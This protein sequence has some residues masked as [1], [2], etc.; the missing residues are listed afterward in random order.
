MTAELGERPLLL[1]SLTF[2][3]DGDEVVVGRRDI[4]SYGVFP[5][6]GAALLRELVAGR[7]LE[8][9][10]EWYFETFGER[11]D[12][13]EFVAVLHELSFIRAPTDP[14]AAQDDASTVSP[15]THVPGQALGKAAFSNAAWLCYAL[16]VLAAVWACVLDSGLTPMPSHVFFSPYLAVVELVVVFGQTPLIALHEA[17]HVLAGRRLGLT[18]RVRLS[19]RFLTPVVETALDGLVTVP[20]RQ[21]ALPMLAGMLADVLAVSGLTLVAAAT[22]RQDGTVSLLGGLCLALAFTTLP[23]IAWQFFLH[24]RTDLYHLVV[25]L[26]GCDDLH[27]AAKQVPLNQLNAA[28]GK[29]EK[30]REDNVGSRRDRAAARWYAPLL[31]S[32]YVASVAMA[33]GIVLPLAWRFITMTIDRLTGSAASTATFWDAAVVLILTLF[34]FGLAG[35]LAWRERHQ[36][37]RHQDRDIPRRH[38]HAE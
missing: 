29:R 6:D 3:D 4:D 9:A 10:G 15:R 38:Q 32:G 18:T 1:H 35:V 33:A 2:L 13:G 8:A 16:I 22:R 19:Y 20:R 24:L 7:G 27:G 31:L 25:L 17:F 5:S 34:E 12:L 11:V 26:T 30:V 36:T 28:W 14:P 23:R 37:P 21:R